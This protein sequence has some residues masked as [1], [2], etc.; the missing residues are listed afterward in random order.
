MESKN[1]LISSSQSKRGKPLQK[2]STLRPCCTLTLTRILVYSTC[3]IA[4]TSGFHLQSLSKV[5]QLEARHSHVDSNCFSYSPLQQSCF[6]PS[7]PGT[8]RFTPTMP[9]Q[10]LTL[11][12]CSSDLTDKTSKKTFIFRIAK[13]LMIPFQL[14]VCLRCCSDIRL[15][16]LLNLLITFWLP[17]NRLLA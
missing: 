4:A 6:D 15:Y 9:S 17:R 8:I 7:S 14:V 1:Y 10:N 3:C 2:V 5:D 12:R 13:R 16:L 11:L